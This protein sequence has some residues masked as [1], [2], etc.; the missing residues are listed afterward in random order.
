MCQWPVGLETSLGAC[1]ANVWPVGLES[2]GACA[3]NVWP[4]GLEFLS[5]V[6][7]NVWPVGWESLGACAAA[8]VVVPSW[9]G[10]GRGLLG[11]GQSAWQPS[12][13]DAWQP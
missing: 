13:N 2:L 3:A 6:L 4:V 10:G 8:A 11:R 1:V 12:G 5:A 7:A 9:I